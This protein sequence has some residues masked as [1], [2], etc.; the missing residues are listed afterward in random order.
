MSHALASRIVLP[1][2]AIVAPACTVDEPDLGTSVSEVI[3]CPR[4]DGCGDNS[5]VTGPWNYHD[6]NVKGVA[7]AAGLSVDG[8]WRNGQRYDPKIEGGTN[9]VATRNGV[10]LQGLSL[11]GGAFHI[12]DRYGARYEVRID[13]V[14]PKA[15]SPTT[16]WVGPATRIET[17]A[18][19]YT[20]PDNSTDPSP[21][22]PY[23]TTVT[24]ES[25]PR[26]N[27]AILFSG[28]KYDAATLTVTA[29]SGQETQDWINIG[30][31]GSALAKLVLM[32][33]ASAG[34]LISVAGSPAW[35]TS[36][37][38]RQA[39]LKMYT[40]DFCNSGTRWTNAGTPLHWMNTANWTQS[41]P[42]EVLGT[43]HAN[44]G[45]WSPDG[46]LCLDTHRLDTAT[47]NPNEQAILAECAYVGHPL[48]ACSD[49]TIQTTVATWPAGALIH[50]VVP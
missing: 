16:F 19:S 14:S 2:L 30:C 24:S 45:Y 5:P 17:Y 10:K 32:R 7:N 25:W 4:F 9:L 13:A 41:T 1:F 8:F 28:D 31:S 27:E 42:S 29:I 36:Q 50:S 47:S 48:P 43:E 34:S 46:A 39:L 20:G 3:G 22:C 49:H 37:A 35:L 6:F 18:L 23:P 12:T 15:T 44:E 26:R 38:Q 40:G 33:H 11:V 21:V